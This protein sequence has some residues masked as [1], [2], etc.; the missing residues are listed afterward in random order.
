MN[1]INKIG[2]RSLIGWHVI[3]TKPRHE[4]K[5]YDE[6]LFQKFVSYLPMIKQTSKWSDRYKILEKPLFPSYVFVFLNNIPEYHQTLKINGVVSYI[7][8]NNKPAKV[9]EAEIE[10][11][12]RVIDNC[13]QIEL[14][15]QDIEPG[16]Y[17]FIQTGPLAGFECEVISL[18]RKNRILVRIN[19]LRQ[20]ITAKINIDNL[21][22][23]VK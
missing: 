1:A 16:T 10:T 15:Q 21:L 9:K 5:V 6:L 19:S 13:T 7:R 22:M 3:C 11:I 17:C 2:D 18:N 14:A 12:K 23:P 20:N 4:K 8:F